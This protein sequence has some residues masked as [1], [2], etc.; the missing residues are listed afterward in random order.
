MVRFPEFLMVYPLP[1]QVM[2]PIP[3]LSSIVSD[4]CSA[5]SKSAPY[6]L[7]AAVIVYPF[8]FRVMLFVIK[9]PLVGV[10][11]AFRMMV[12]PLGAAAN[13]AVRVA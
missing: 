8:K 1:S 10:I 2:L 11:L 3:R 6:G 4:P 9:R 13:A 5:I 7:D 12:L